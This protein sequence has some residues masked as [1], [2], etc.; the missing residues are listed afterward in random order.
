MLPSR[1]HSTDFPSRSRSSWLLRLALV[2]LMAGLLPAGGCKRPAAES[3]DADSGFKMVAPRWKGGMKYAYQT[4]LTIESNID[5]SALL[6]ESSEPAEEQPLQHIKVEVKGTWM[7]QPIRTTL[8][9]NYFICGMRGAD[10]RGTDGNIDFTISTDVQRATIVKVDQD[11]KIVG[12]WYDPLASETARGLI[13]QM[14]A[15]TQFVVPRDPGAE[16]VTTEPDV[17]G[18]CEAR[19]A[20]QPDSDAELAKFRVI[21][22]KSRTKYLDPTGSPKASAGTTGGQLT[23]V[24]TPEGSIDFTVNTVMK[25]IGIIE[26][27]EE[28][29]GTI[30]G[31]TVTKTSL[32]LSFTLSNPTVTTVD[33]DRMAQTLMREQMQGPPEPLIVKPSTQEAEDVIDKTELSSD[34]LETLVAR[35][36][37]AELGQSEDTETALVLK[38]KALARLHPEVCPELARILTETAPGSLTMRVLPPALATAQ[39]AEAQAALITAI[40]ARIDELDTIIPLIPVVAMGA[41]TSEAEAW[42]TETAF[43]HP[44]P[45]VASTAQLA[46]G[47]LARRLVETTPDRAAAIAAQFEKRLKD[48]A[49]PDD[50]VQAVLVLGNIGAA[51]S[52]PGLQERTADDAPQVRAAATWALRFLPGEDVDKVL[53]ERAARDQSPD[54]RRQAVSAMSFRPMNAATAEVLVSALAGDA[55]LSVRSEALSLLW[56]ERA[57]IPA[58]RAAVE[59]AAKVDASEDLRKTAQAF[60][61]SEP[62]PPAK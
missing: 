28:T 23:P 30:A 26:G 34:T 14:V 37:A 13:R 41:P 44:E 7:I 38:F 36:A 11:Q 6:G 15:A 19:Y 21:V 40:K 29:T 52:W 35:L 45:N 25:C 48:A 5:L 17:A 42:L 46:L 57:G 27:F 55:D 61:D 53:R 54:V 4:N 24:L 60:L 3:E 51:S 32:R 31:R 47:S 9:G 2:L 49:T 62:A 10:V 33:E 43:T 22:R 8:P 12:L 20:V 50:A 1:S 59:Q 56:R 16:W 18:E 58:A 39:S